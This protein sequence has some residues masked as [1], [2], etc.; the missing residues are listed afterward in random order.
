MLLA[1]FGVDITLLLALFAV[2]I[3]LLMAYSLLSLLAVDEDE[4]EE[5][6]EEDGVHS[7]NKNPIQAIW[8]TKRLHCSRSSSLKL[9][10]PKCR[11]NGLPK[12]SP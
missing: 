2:D 10:L 1:S 11:R 8:G 4:E 9:D 5:D 3:A 6:G 12:T 7:K